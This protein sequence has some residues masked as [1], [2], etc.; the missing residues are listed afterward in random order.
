MNEDIQAKL[1]SL[2]DDFLI[3]SMAVVQPSIDK[4]VDEV[5][6]N[7]SFFG[8]N[9]FDLKNTREYLRQSFENSAKEQFYKDFMKILNK[10][11]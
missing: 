1:Q 10:K 9:D 4:L 3:K 11:I 5:T 2:F 8:M 6:T 7:M